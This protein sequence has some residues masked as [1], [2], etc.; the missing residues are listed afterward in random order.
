M[1]ERSIDALIASRVLNQVVVLDS[2]SNTA[3]TYG[4]DMKPI[5][6]PEFSTDKDDLSDL[7]DL[8]T[9][10][11]YELRVRQTQQGETPMW[12]AVFVPNQNVSALP[13]TGE[14][15]GL[16]VCKAALSVIDGTNIRK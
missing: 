16:A 3:V 9:E 4:K 6:V 15:K 11:G 2:N 12:F 10:K 8:F 13:S 1:T 7:I 14:T 5:K